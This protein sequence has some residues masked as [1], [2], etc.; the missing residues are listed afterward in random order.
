VCGVMWVCAAGPGEDVGLA[1]VERAPG[2]QSEEEKERRRPRMRKRGME[3]E[4]VSRMRKLA[5]MAML[6][7]CSCFPAC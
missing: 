6:S 4:I 1:K 2:E 3:K 7:A 5:K